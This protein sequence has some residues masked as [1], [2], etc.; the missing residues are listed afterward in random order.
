[1]RGDDIHHESMCKGIYLGRACRK[2]IAEQNFALTLWLSGEANEFSTGKYPRRLLM[3][4]AIDP[5]ESRRTFL[6]NSGSLIATTSLS[7]AACLRG[8]EKETKAWKIPP[9]EDLMREHGI[10]RRIMLV[11]DEIA[12]RL[13]QGEEFP[14]QVLTEANNIIRRF[15]QDYHEMNEQF[16]MFNFFGNTGKMVELVAILYQQ[17]LAGRKLIDKVKNLSTENYLKDTSNRLK[18]AEFLQT[19]NL[20]YRHHAAWEDTIIFPAFRSIISPKDFTAL[21]KTFQR[22]EE[23]QFGVDGYEKIVGQV[24]DLEKKLA[25]HDLQQFTPKF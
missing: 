3:K 25:I 7:V 16:H 8:P 1:M 2:I 13:K 6:V 11:Y 19:F 10:L 23:K 4:D 24:A 18:V 17:H 14:L 20:V 5:R 21:G 22:E 9:T 12:R 15:M